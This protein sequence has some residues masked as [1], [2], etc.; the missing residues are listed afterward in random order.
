MPE[1]RCEKRDPQN[2]RVG[3]G[4]VAHLSPDTR[5]VFLGPAQ[6]GVF[7]QK[8]TSELGCYIVNVTDFTATGTIQYDTIE[9]GGT[10]DITA[11]GA[12]GGSSEVGAGGGGA[13]VSGDVYL[14]PGTVLEIV[15]GVEGGT[16]LNG[17]GGGGGSFVIEMGATVAQDIILAVAGGGGG[18]DATGKPGFVCNRAP[19]SK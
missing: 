16:G 12:Q 19:E 15:V 8:R 10:Y 1:W 17:G 2:Q 7:S 5:G 11:D 13:V 14:Q 3:V 6:F 4:S 18:G 9:S